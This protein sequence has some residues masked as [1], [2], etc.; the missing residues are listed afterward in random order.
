MDA[1]GVFHGLLRRSRII[2]RF[3]KQVVSIGNQLVSSPLTAYV[4]RFL[5]R[6]DKSEKEKTREEK[7]YFDGKKSEID[8]NCALFGDEKSRK[9]Y[10][11]VIEY[12]S[13]LNPKAIKNLSEHPR[14]QYAD[15]VL[16][17][18]RSTEVFVDVGAGFGE[19]TETVK[20]FFNENTSGEFSF[21]P[22]FID[23]DPFNLD[24]CRKTAGGGGENLFLEC[25]CARKSGE[26]VSFLSG[27]Y[28]SSRIVGNGENAG[29]K[30]RETAAVD[31]LCDTYNIAPTYIKYDIEGADFDALLGSA[32]T[33]E[34]Y[35]PRLAVSIYH[36]KEH[37]IEI[38]QWI[39]GNYPF[40]KL[41]VRH[42]SGAAFDTVLYCI[43]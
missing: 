17:P 7:E 3:P 41:Y 28:L 14:H 35:R 2:R 1:A 27:L 20:K 29:V 24:I 31:D 5:N 36:R 18:V 37:V 39:N 34:K 16:L 22:V 33:I 21:R 4:L 10:R 32:R 11:G 30:E 40:Y 12:R 42:Y 25:V 43:P 19:S 23:A 8:S 6:T 26:K 9:I 38:I 15:G 13:T